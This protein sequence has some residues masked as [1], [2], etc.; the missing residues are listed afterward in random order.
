MKFGQLVASLKSAMGMNEKSLA[1]VMDRIT[2][3]IGYVERRIK[4][5]SHSIFDANQQVLIPGQNN[6]LD[7]IS[8]DIYYFIADGKSHHDFTRTPWY[9]KLLKQNELVKDISP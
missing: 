5:M 1:K 6:E 3:A 7:F 2:I 9:L 4:L 8:D